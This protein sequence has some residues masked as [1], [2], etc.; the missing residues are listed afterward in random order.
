MARVAKE[1]REWAVAMG[2]ARQ[3]R[4]DQERLIARLN[5]RMNM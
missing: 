1:A 5:A 2:Q 4:D 3:K